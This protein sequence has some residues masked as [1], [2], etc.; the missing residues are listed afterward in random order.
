MLKLRELGDCAFGVVLLA[1]TFALGYG[2]MGMLFEQAALASA[3][4]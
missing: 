4:H 1:V 2:F 3:L